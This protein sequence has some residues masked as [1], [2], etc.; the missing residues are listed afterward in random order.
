MSRT[1]AHRPEWV[2]LNDHPEL[3]IERHDHSRGPCTLPR[4]PYTPAATGWVP[5]GC[6]VLLD[7]NVRLCS[8]AMC[9]DRL[10]RVRERR[11]ARTSE[12]A[13]TRALVGA[14]DEQSQAALEAQLNA[15]L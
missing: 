11:S 9:S 2:L 10:R 5:D 1:D 15:L 13:L 3:T 8:C 6:Y 7:H 4:R 12:R 14:G